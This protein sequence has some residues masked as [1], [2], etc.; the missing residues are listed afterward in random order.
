M[1]GHQPHLHCG[2]VL[3][4][5]GSAAIGSPPAEVWRLFD[6]TGNNLVATATANGGL[7]EGS[8]MDIQTHA[9]LLRIY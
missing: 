9:Q 3:G 8:Y 1:R 2:E 5:L 6:G 7:F 4:C